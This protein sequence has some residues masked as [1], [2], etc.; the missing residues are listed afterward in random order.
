MVLLWGSAVLSAIVDNIP[1]VATI[2]PVVAE[3]INANGNT[4]RSQ[5]LWWALAL[6]ADP[7]GNATAVGAS[8]NVVVLGLAERAGKK[9]TFWEFTKYGLVVAVVTVALS[10]PYLWPRYFVLA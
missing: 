7:G 5:V 3:M 4:S 9:I 1:Y 6:G 2:S 8:A 10:M